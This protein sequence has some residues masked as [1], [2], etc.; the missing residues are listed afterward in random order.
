[1]TGWANPS[2]IPIP[3]DVSNINT[4]DLGQFSPGTKAVYESMTGAGGQIATRL[5]SIVDNPGG[6]EG[7]V[8]WHVLQAI[9]P[10]GHDIFME[11]GN[12]NSPNNN[13]GYF[14]VGFDKLV[15]GTFQVLKIRNDGDDIGRLAF[16]D[17]TTERAQ[18][19]VIPAPSGGTTID[20]QARAAIT[21]IL[22]V[23]GAA[24]G[25]FGLTA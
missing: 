7:H 8:V 3:V 20:T 24:A 14:N 10:D 21:A 9:T 16:F 5:F 18:A 1:M 23:L 13:S 2:G 22:N 12:E 4:V 25:G 6:A 15:G 17:G 11:M 19:A